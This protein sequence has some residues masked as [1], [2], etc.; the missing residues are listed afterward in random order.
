M[1]DLI[2]L[3]PDSGNVDLWVESHRRGISWCEDSVESSGGALAGLLLYLGQHLI[4]M[5]EIA[6]GFIDEV[7]NAIVSPGFH[8]PFPRKLKVGEF[9][10]GDDVAWLGPGSFNQPPLCDLPSAG[11]SDVLSKLAP[12]ARG[13]AI[14]KK[15]PSI[16][17]FLLG[18]GIGARFP[19]VSF[20]H[21]G[22]QEREKEGCDLE[23]QEMSIHRILE[24]GGIWWSHVWAGPRIYYVLSAVRHAGGQISPSLAGEKAW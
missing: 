4:L 14:E 8:P 18:Q 24:E 9:F 19:C 11:G 22:E 17:S 13:F 21:G 7:F 15:T 23:C 16:G 10:P 5:A 12:R 1:G 6:P 3:Y 2:G 20:R